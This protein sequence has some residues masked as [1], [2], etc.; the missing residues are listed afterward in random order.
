MLGT[1]KNK[2]KNHVNK[3][4]IGERR[5]EERSINEIGQNRKD[6]KEESNMP[7]NEIG[8]NRKKSKE[9]RIMYIN[10]AGQS[11]KKSKILAMSCGLA[12]GFAQTAPTFRMLIG[13]SAGVADQRNLLVKM[14]QRQEKCRKD[15]DCYHPK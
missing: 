5:E 15:P 10:E 1:S 8:Q 2:R 11:R 6:S 13:G 9:E 14:Q 3:G 7:I 4:E 12:T